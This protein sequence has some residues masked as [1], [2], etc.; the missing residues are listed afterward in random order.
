MANLDTDG[1]YNIA[2]DGSTNPI[3]RSYTVTSLTTGA[4]YGFKIQ[5]LNF[6]GKGQISNEAVFTSCTAPVSMLP[7]T[8]VETTQTTIKIS[9]EY[10]Q[11][12]GG[13]PLTGFEVL[14]DDGNSGSFTN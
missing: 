13:C 10:P 5:A 8:I 12:D 2:Y 7:P 9:W 11:D 14:M 1:I 6:N 3:R 4:S